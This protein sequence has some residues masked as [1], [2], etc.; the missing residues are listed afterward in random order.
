MEKFQETKEGIGRRGGFIVFSA[1]PGHR[2]RRDS[3]ERGG[4]GKG[5]RGERESDQGVV[6]GVAVAE[7]LWAAARREVEGG[8]AR[9]PT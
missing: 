7:R 9:H 6:P 8:R 4:G 1:P 5:N 3:T 2:Q